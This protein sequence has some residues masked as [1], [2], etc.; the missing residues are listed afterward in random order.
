MSI[1]GWEDADQTAMR[2]ALEEAQ[3]AADA[4]EI[5]VGAI[6]VS[7]GNIIGRGH[8]RSIADNDP[9]GHAEIVA[10]RQ[11]AAAA[12]NY[13]LSGAT[14]YVTLEPCAMCMGA[15]I[16]ARI[17]RLV[18]G[19]YDDRAGAAGSVLDLSAV[20][21]LNHRIEVNGGLF[22]EEGGDVLTKFFEAQR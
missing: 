20:P 21:A 15:L 18:F 4:G 16:Q 6:V 13:R 2:E 5:P 19:A 1:T 22:A 12:D 14:L 7:S 8:N 11:A 9:T 10:L 3:A 17:A